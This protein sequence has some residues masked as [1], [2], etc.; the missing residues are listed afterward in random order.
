VGK[1]RGQPYNGATERFF[2]RVG[3]CFS[4]IH[5]TRMKGLPSTNTLAYYE[6]SLIM[7]VK[8][9]ITF[10]PGADAIKLFTVLM[11]CHSMRSLSLGVLKQFYSSI[12]HGMAV[13]YHGKNVF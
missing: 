4:N 12:N 7:A 5:Y 6:H 3:S 13:N 1:A 10:G 8:S 2:D 9:F 11:Y